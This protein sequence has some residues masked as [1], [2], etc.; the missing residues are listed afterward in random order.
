MTIALNYG[1]DSPLPPSGAFRIGLAEPPAGE[2]GALYWLTLGQFARAFASGALPIPPLLPEG[3]ER[4]LVWYTARELRDA[5][6]S[7]LPRGR[8]GR[9]LRNEFHVYPHAGF[10]YELLEVHCAMQ[11]ACESRPD[12]AAAEPAAA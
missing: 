2:P 7:E 11:R 1:P 4:G 8:L 6:G 10:G 12:L 5:I 3:M 9:L